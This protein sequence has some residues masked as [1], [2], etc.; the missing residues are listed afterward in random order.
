MS[1]GAAPRNL[2]PTCP[3]QCMYVRIDRADADMGVASARRATV[4]TLVLRDRGKRHDPSAACG[5]QRL[6]PPSHTFQHASERS[7]TCFQ[8]SAPTPRP[9]FNFRNPH[10]R[11]AAVC[12]SVTEGAM[13]ISLA[14]C[15]QLLPASAVSAHWPRAGHRHRSASH[16]TR[17]RCLR[18]G[19][20][21][22]RGRAVRVRAWQ[23]S[24]TADHGRVR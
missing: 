7:L 15:G 1:G 5:P 2:P 19:A 16:N 11:R 14:S 18:A 21:Q 23:P 17:P 3:P 10:F 6:Q 8:T 24:G 20:F 4:K 12:Q 9:A 22:T 13:V